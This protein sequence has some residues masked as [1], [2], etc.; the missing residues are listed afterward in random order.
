M[1]DMNFYSG[2]PSHLETSNSLRLRFFDSS[3]RFGSSSCRCVRRC[4]CFLRL[5]FRFRGNVFHLSESLKA[6]IPI[7]SFGLLEFCCGR[8]LNKHA[9]QLPCWRKRDSV[10]VVVVSPSSSLFSGKGK[11]ECIRHQIALTMHRTGGTRSIE[12][13]VHIYTFTF[14]CFRLPYL[15]FKFRLGRV[16]FTDLY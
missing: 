11:I 7:S 13:S 10:V 3:S 16:P 14:P 12:R 2:F 8:I 4:C 9:T 6:A 15:A 5:L 1:V